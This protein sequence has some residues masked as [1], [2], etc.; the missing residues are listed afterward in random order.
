MCRA[1]CFPLSSTNGIHPPETSLSEQVTQL[2]FNN[3]VLTERLAA[4]EL[5]QDDQGWQRLVGSADTEFSREGLRNIT[6]LARVMYLKNPLL[7]RGVTVKKFYVWGSGMNVK[8][9]D[10]D[11]NAVIQ[12]FMDDLKNKVELTSH[13]ARMGKEV[14]LQVDANIFFIFF[15]S[16]STGHVR[17]RSIPFAEIEDVITNP[18]DAKEPW[19]YKRVWVEQRLNFDTGTYEPIQRTAY[20]PDYGYD[21]ETRPASIGGFPIQWDTPIY[22]VKVGGFSGWKFGLSEIYAAL[23]WA[24]AYKEFLEN[25]AT[26]TKALARFAW[27]LTTPG[28]KTGIATAKAR[29]GTTIGNGNGETNPPSV[30]GSMFIAAQDGATLNPVKTAGAT[31]SADDGRRMS[32]MAMA[33]LGLPETFFADASVGSLATAKSLDRPTELM[34]ID[35]QTFWADVH[36][37]IYNFVLLMAVKYGPLKGKAEIVVDEDGSDGTERLVWNEGIDPGIDIDFPP[38]V[39]DDI[40]AQVN[41][42]VAA[43]TLNGNADAGILPKKVITT[44]FANLLSIPNAEDIVD[45]LFND[46]GTLKNPPPQPA[47]APTTGTPSPVVGATPPANPVPAAEAQ[48]V[49]AVR[50]IREALA[51]VLRG[52]L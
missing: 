22:H 51:A 33:V 9:K 10:D 8:A 4:L 16:K 36:R 35:R 34:M 12:A 38:L 2:A 7:L 6:L 48:M 49:E 29:L 30:A 32:L 26:I 20:Y 15:V 25:W 27:T 3:E 19:Y 44:A 52:V 42:L 37:N 13:A 45:E 43:V 40:V 50:E 47:V 21:P 17:M 39:T 23:D 41:A 14:D 5:A 18:D 11:I 31:T 24:R 46:D 28:G 1:F